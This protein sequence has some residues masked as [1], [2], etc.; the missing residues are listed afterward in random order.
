[1]KTHTLYPVLLASAL[2]FSGCTTVGFHAPTFG[3][4]KKVPSASQIDAYPNRPI[5]IIVPTGAGGDTD[6]GA[7]LL[8]RYLGEE[9]DT[10]FVVTNIAGAGGS[11]GSREVLEADPDGYKVLFFHNNLLINKLYGLST[12]NHNDFKIAGIALMDHGD[13]FIVHGDAPY[14]TA[15]EL[16][17]AA[18]EQPGELSFATEVGGYTHLQ[19]MAFEEATG[20]DLKPIDVGGASDKL[21]A[22][23]GNQVDIV[24]IAYG[25]TADYIENGDFASVG[26][27]SSEQHALYDNTPTFLEQGIDVEFEKFFFFAFPKETPDAIV[28]RFSEA[29][30]EVVENNEAYQEQAESYY[31][32]PT[33]MAPEEATRYM[34]DVS[35]SYERLIERL[36]TQTN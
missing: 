12:F 7:R 14:Q 24:P 21:V 11:M 18:I 29:L 19:M 32:I 23:L 17:Q 27:L 34:D 6:L 28:A 30:K 16:A 13:T 3:S 9:M 15:N 36:E 33:Y 22:L 31:T 8:G 25:V 4:E 35:H 5:E 26:V 20:A 10:S 2:L 1:M